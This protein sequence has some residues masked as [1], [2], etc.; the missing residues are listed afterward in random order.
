MRSAHVSDG[1]DGDSESDS[2]CDAFQSTLPVLDSVSLRGKI[3]DS[4]FVDA[5]ALLT[6]GPSQHAT[7]DS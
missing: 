5:L 3:P 2:S 4:K 7:M 6:G 1:G